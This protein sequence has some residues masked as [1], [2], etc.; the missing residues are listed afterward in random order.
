[1]DIWKEIVSIIVSDGVF[2]VLFVWLFFVQI[3]DSSK[4]EDKYQQTIEELTSNLQIMEDIKQ[5]ISEIK[6]I[7]DVDDE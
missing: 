4:R 2:A 6:Q 5:D 1:M 3:R 7:L